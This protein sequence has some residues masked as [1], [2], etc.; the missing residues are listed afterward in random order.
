MPRTPF[1]DG[2]FDKHITRNPVSRA[3]LRGH[4]AVLRRFLR[5]AEARR[6]LEIGCGRGAIIERMLDG[7][8]KELRFTGCDLDMNALCLARSRLPEA[9]FVNG[10]VYGMPFC[11][12]AFDTVILCEMLEHLEEPERAMEQ[13]AR[14]APKNIILSVPREPLWR[15]LNMLRGA[16]WGAGGNTPGHIQHFSTAGFLRFV[17]RWF[18]V[19]EVRTP[20]PWTMVLAEPK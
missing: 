16:Y 3:L 2:Y 10:S 19:R 14:L 13:S 4:Y 5:L 1:P 7:G 17:S 20:V 8:M 15:A 11:S 9:V 6:V 18:R 12:G